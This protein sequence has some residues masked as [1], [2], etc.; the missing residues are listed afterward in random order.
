MASGETLI[1][2]G[3]QSQ[4]F[5]SVIQHIPGGEKILTCMQCGTCSGSC[6]TGDKMPFTPRYIMRM[7]QL[8]LEEEVLR[9]DAIWLCVDCYTCTV[10]CP[11]GIKVSDIMAGLRTLA[12][13]RGY[14]KPRDT[15]FHRNF[16]SIVRRY[17]RTYEPELLLRYNFRLNPFRLFK[18]TRLG[19]AMLFHGKIGF[20]PELIHGRGEV[21]RIYKTADEHHAAA[22]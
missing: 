5:V 11:R 14:A 1:I 3:I 21:Q 17:G 13:E 12:I 9:S 19:L 8:G 10:R 2:Q 16:L 20:L 22:K 7:L 15:A 6:P 18:Q 4:E